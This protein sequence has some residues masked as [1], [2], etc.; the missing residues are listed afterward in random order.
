[1]ADL[2]RLKNMSEKD[3]KMMK[4]AEVMMGPEPEEMGFIKNLFWGNVREDLLFPYPERDEEEKKRF[5]K[6]MVELDDYMKYEH[7][8][9][10]ID[11]EQ[12]IPQW[13]LKRLFDMGVMGMTIPEEN[14]GLSLSI[15]SYNQVLERIGRD[16]ASTS[17]VVSAHQS[18]GCKALLLYGTEAQK[19]KWLP[20]VAKEKLS[21]FCLSEANVGCDA[22]GQET[23]CELSKDGS[24]YI[25]NGEK[26]WSTSAA[27]SALFTVMTKQRIVS[28]KTGKARDRV[29][30]LIVTPDMEG[31]DIFEK[32]RAKCGI[33]G[34]WQGRIRFTNVK[35][36]RKNLLHKEGRGLNVALTCL[37][38]G[39]CTL[40]AGVLGAAR[41]AT[42]QA[43]KWSQL[44]YQFQRPLSD[45]ELVRQR[46]AR[47]EAFVYG[48]DAMLYMTTGMLDRGDKDIMVET[49]V[50]KI[51]CSEMGW[52]TID[53]AMQ[54][55]GG[56]GYM[57]ENELERALR[58]SRLYR[59]AEGANEVMQTFIFG[60]GGKQLAESMVGIQEALLWNRDEAI[61]MNLSRIIKN[62]LN[63][64][65]LSRAL[66]LGAELY[67][68][69]KEPPTRIRNVHRSLIRYARKLAKL[70]QEHS[71]QYKMTGKRHRE[72]IVKRQAVQARLADNTMW[73][74]AFAC[75]LSKLDLQIRKGDQGESFERDKRAA[76]HLMELA[77]LKIQ[78]NIRAL[79]DNA[80]E[81]MEKCASSSLKHIDTLPDSDFYIPE[82]SPVAKPESGKPV[83]NRHIKQFLGDSC[84]DQEAKPNDPSPRSKP[85]VQS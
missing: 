76:I 54:I 14:G 45:F 3:R 69:R 63:P 61:G 50:V 37:N 24:H 2:S 85:E 78:E 1:M 15:T 31:V 17:V 41:G 34:T 59:I 5:D 36:P 22:G 25:L 46:I 75:S 51:F 57:T 65:I 47:M 72:K 64:R 16:C 74:H 20:V 80:D 52:L 79:T 58:D 53:D 62:G 29:T 28:K 48:M 55:M 32:N 68:S 56:E 19:K 23:R 70:A 35:V 27:D 66:L 67:L 9:I 39:R 40:S 84:K 10:Q 42:E 6:L 26:K 60:Y 11:Q 33:R 77:D 38:Y 82:K 83:D 73:I 21:A 12:F 71:H 13:V 49:A 30:A 8:S 4:E 18:I 81:S 7:P 44:R 43:V